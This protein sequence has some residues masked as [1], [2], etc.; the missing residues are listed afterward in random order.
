[1]DIQWIPNGNHREKRNISQLISE[2]GM[3]LHAIVSFPKMP[4]SMLCS[5]RVPP[6]SLQESQRPLLSHLHRVP[7]VF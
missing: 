5:V 4:H 1:M 6:N 3:P 7:P 2:N